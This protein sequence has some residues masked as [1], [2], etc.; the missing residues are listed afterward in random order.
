MIVWCSV[1]NKSQVLK[2]SDIIRFKALLELTFA[3]FVSPYW[4]EADWKCRGPF[5]HLWMM[6]MIEHEHIEWWWVDE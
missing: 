6:V 4:T 2:K 3:T 5:I 1:H